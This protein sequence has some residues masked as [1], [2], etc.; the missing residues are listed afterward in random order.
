VL[1]CLSADLSRVRSVRL[2]TGT[3]QV[4]FLECTGATKTV[5]YTYMSLRISKL[6]HITHF[7]LKLIF[8]IYGN[9]LGGVQPPLQT[10]PHI[11]SIA[12]YE[13]TPGT[14]MG[15]QLARLIRRSPLYQSTTKLYFHS[16]PRPA[17]AAGPGA[18]TGADRLLLFLSDARRPRR[19]PP[20]E[21]RIPA[22]LKVNSSKFENSAAYKTTTS[23]GTVDQ[24]R[25][26]GY[27]KK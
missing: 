6:V 3:Q 21:G 19:P 5:T 15:L 13:V 11:F 1:E 7:S 4:D 25:D 20:V 16:P 10:P 23:V 9:S 17:A 22:H 24:S 18:G 2:P 27:E 12:F 8:F 26:T 14:K